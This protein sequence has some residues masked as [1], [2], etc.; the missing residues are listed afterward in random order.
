MR[1]RHQLPPN[2]KRIALTGARA[3]RVCEWIESLSRVRSVDAIQ[4]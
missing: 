4:G 2:E 3:S 1:A